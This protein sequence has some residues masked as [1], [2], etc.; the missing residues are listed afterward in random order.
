MWKIVLRR[1]YECARGVSPP[2]VYFHFPSAFRASGHVALCMEMPFALGETRRFPVLPHR[3]D[4]NCTRS[5]AHELALRQ[6]AK[7]E[8]EERGGPACYILS[9]DCG[10]LDLALARY[11]LFLVA[12]IMFPDPHIMRR[13]MNL[14]EERQTPGGARHA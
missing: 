5:R 10:D 6:T 14:R 4:L 9:G 13:S 7:E 12:A 11:L 8:E 1:I 2:A 3:Y